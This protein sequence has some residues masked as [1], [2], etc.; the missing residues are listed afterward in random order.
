MRGFSDLRSS[1]V[2]VVLV[3]SDLQPSMKSLNKNII[4]NNKRIIHKKVVMSDIDYILGYKLS[5]PGI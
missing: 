4:R 2:I 1:L 3:P 5:S